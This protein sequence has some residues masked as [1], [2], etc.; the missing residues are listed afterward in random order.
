VIYT[1]KGKRET[2]KYSLSFLLLLLFLFCSQVSDESLITVKKSVI[3]I[4]KF[5]YLI[6][7]DIYQMALTPIVKVVDLYVLF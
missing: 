4:R 2:E 6:F 7:L 1:N 5:D 3:P